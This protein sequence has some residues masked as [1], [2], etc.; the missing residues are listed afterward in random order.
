MTAKIM[1]GVILRW[2][3]LCQLT[4]K[5]NHENITK[6]TRGSTTQLVSGTVNIRLCFTLGKLLTM[7]LEAI[8]DKTPV[9]NALV[10]KYLTGAVF[11][12]SMAF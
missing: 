2:L 5:L 8:E 9:T 11:S 10:N 7:C 12:N 4:T 3:N 1:L 6:I